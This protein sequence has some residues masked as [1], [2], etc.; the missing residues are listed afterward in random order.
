LKDCP[1]WFDNQLI[2]LP[3]HIWLQWIWFYRKINAH[4]GDARGRSSS[5]LPLLPK[6]D[7]TQSF[8]MRFHPLKD[9]TAYPIHQLIDLQWYI[10][11][12]AT[13]GLVAR[14]GWGVAPGVLQ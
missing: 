8:S 13:M 5:P 1:A 6:I 14:G 10:Y 11:L 7:V 12:F 4:G 3:S 9:C 2:D